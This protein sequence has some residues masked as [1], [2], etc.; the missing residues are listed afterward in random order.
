L[1]GGIVWRLAVETLN[2]EK[3]LE[4]PS[5]EVVV[6]RRGK[7]YPTDHPSLDF[8]DDDLSTD[9]LDD[10]CGINYVL[11]GKPSS[12]L[13]VFNPS[14]RLLLFYPGKGSQYSLKSWF[15][16]YNTW[17][18]TSPMNHWTERNHNEF[19]RRMKEIMQGAQPMTA[20]EWSQRLKSNNHTRRLKVNNEKF[21]EEFLDRV[22]P[23]ASPLARSDLLHP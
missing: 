12:S 16:L 10:I 18:A 21:S 4:G 17:A 23:V 5:V 19:T 20:S 2:L 15:P 9:E 3:C 1:K 13:L 7:I 8:C 11:T 22:L 6:H 14:N